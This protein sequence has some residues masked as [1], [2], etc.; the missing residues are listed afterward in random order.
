MERWRHRCRS[1]RPCASTRQLT[2]THHF[3][4]LVTPE[5]QPLQLC[6]LLHASVNTRD[7]EVTYSKPALNSIIQVNLL[8]SDRHQSQ[9]DIFTSRELESCGKHQ[10]D[11][12]F[13]KKT[14]STEEGY[15]ETLL[16]L[17]LKMSDNFYDTFWK[18]CIFCLL[19][20][21]FIN[22]FGAKAWKKY[23]LIMENVMYTSPKPCLRTFSP[24]SGHQLI[25]CY[26]VNKAIKK[27]GNQ[28]LAI[29][30]LCNWSPV[31]ETWAVK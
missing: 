21:I 15:K 6:E 28:V 9:S 7:I 13:L 26:T 1:R 14:M 19:Q 8:K 24:H 23:A 16:F 31:A 29:W 25:L 2:D 5:V 12:V 11:P 17:V 20:Y 10:T 27:Q 4:E 22:T 30:T 3:S 18:H